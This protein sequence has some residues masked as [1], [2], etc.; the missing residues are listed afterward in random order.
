MTAPVSPTEF[1]PVGPRSDNFKRV[2]IEKIVVGDR[3]RTFDPNWASAIAATLPSMGLKQPIEV[4]ADGDR[5]RLIG[6]RHRLE[7][8][9]IAGWID[10]PARI[11]TLDDANIDAS[12]AL[13]EAMETVALP[14][15]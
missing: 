9:V 4:S 15:L 1:R 2:A 7:A 6:G 5:F 11:V 12:A 10:I 13:H 3:Q 14:A 8:A